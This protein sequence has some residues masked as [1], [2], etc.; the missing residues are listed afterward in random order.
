MS[1]RQVAYS[2]Y[3]N[4]YYKHEYSVVNSI[5][6]KSGL[7]EFWKNTLQ[8]QKVVKLV[9]HQSLHLKFITLQLSFQK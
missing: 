7:S 2:L 8:L 9:W 4:T 1:V 6:P 5:W 3:A